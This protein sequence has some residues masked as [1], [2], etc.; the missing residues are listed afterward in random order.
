M[1]SSPIEALRVS[2]PGRAE[3]VY[4]LLAGIFLG[5][6]VMTNAIAGKFF[7]LFGQELSC[8]IIAYPV[9]FLAT[10]LISELYGRKR[11]NLVV[12]VGFAVS[13]FV[14]LVVIIANQ[15]P[16]FE[17]SPVD[18]RSFAVV[19]GLLPGIV[20]GS[21]IA[22]LTAQFIDVQLFEFWRDLTEGRHLWLRNNASTI[23][24]QLVDTVL[25]VTIALVI[26][27]QVDTN[28]E[29]TPIA[30]SVWWNI[31]IG[32]YLFKAALALLDTPL[33]Y[34]LTAWLR[35]YIAASAREGVLAA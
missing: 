3:Q 32:Q 16:I 31:I 18:Q 30:G 1:D 22:Y 26:W 34:A 29:T 7:V 15:V 28:P 19:F 35:R 20:F 8:G 27:P 9:T 25:V 4:L 2:A 10:D 13:V 12:K 11:A 17:Q 14:T 21:M 5:A 6:L 33:F 24:S 23:F